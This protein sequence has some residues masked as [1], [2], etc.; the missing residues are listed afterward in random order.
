MFSARTLARQFTV[1][2]PRLG[3]QL[4]GEISVPTANLQR[5]MAWVNQIL[6]RML[7]RGFV[8]RRMDRSPYYHQVPAHRWWIT[9]AGAE[10]LAA[11]LWAGL[12]AKRFE[13]QRRWA[14][15]GAA[16]RRR[17]EDALTQ[18]YTDYDPLTVCLNERT[19]AICRLRAE[20]CTLDSIG[21]VFGISRERVRQII[22]DHR[23]P[24]C[25]CPRCDDAEW[26]GVGDGEVVV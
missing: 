20:G 6:D 18:A 3:R 25:R 19:R 26:F 13:E 8:T 17:A 1:P 10:F 4:R 9:E 24:T 2:D 21:G 11:G 15:L 14:E 7:R 22:A 5:R 23:L 16:R 12:R